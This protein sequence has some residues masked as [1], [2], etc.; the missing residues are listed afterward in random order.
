[1]N[2]I[3]TC[4]GGPIGPP[5]AGPETRSGYFFG[6]G[7]KSLSSFAIALSRFFCRFSG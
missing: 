6:F 4:S 1:M 5:C 2:D 3:I 7:G